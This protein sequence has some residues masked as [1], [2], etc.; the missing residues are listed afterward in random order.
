MPP[1]TLAFTGDPPADELLATDPLALLIGMLLDQQFP[2]ERAFHSP[3]ELKERLGGRLDTAEIAA[4]DAEALA[5]VFRGPP[6]LHRYPGSMAGRTQ[7]LCRALLERFE[8]QAE[9]VW[10]SAET[11]Q[12]LFANLRSLPGFGEQK[13]RIFTAVL[14]KRLGVT[15][16]G[17]EEAAGPYAAAGYYSVAD[18]D[19]PGALAAVREH[20]K[21]VKSAAK[22]A[23][24]GT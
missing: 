23:K 24:A 7:E 4:M 18:I 15:L 12:K 19:G 2:M 8:G 13:S 5:A 3:Y 14:A 1:K 16:P 17:W 10:A 21:A 22:A 11:G 9:N 20:K 6:A